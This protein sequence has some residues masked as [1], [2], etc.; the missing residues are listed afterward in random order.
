LSTL[1]CLQGTNET[2]PSDGSSCDQWT[3]SA[4]SCPGKSIICDL[5]CNSL[6]ASQ[7]GIYG[8]CSSCTSQD[9]CVWCASANSCTS[10]YEAL[11]SDCR[12]MVFD[13]PCPE[14]FVAGKYFDEFSF[15][16]CQKI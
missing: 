14:S 2:G 7:C 13:P 8:S 6:V 15:V 9:K 5:G 11:N 4:D 3:F 1:Q 16:T 12:G 10:L